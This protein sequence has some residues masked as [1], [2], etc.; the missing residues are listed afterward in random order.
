MNLSLSLSTQESVVL[1]A[2][3]GEQDMSKSAVMRQA[4]R[5]YQAVHDR[6]KRGEQM[7]F[8]KNGELVPVV[9]MGLPIFD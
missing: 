4:L 7:A 9:I 2:L 8:T 1:D 3:A 6:A 5:L